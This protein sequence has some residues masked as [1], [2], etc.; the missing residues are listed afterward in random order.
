MNSKPDKMKTI[1]QWTWN[2]ELVRSKV[3]RS[4]T[5]GCHPWLGSQSPSAPL[6]GARKNNRPQMTQA[7][8][9]LYREIYNEDCEDKEI[10]HSCGNRN[11]MNE[12]HWLVV[13]VKKHGPTPTNVP[14]AK[15]KPITKSK[16]TRWWDQ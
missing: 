13:D 3:D 1:G 9:I 12:R 7:A 2:S 6:F 10:T 4:D 5:H 14:Q 8:R 15:L 11:C 16:A